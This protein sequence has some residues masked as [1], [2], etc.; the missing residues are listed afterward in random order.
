MKKLLALCTIVGFLAG[1]ETKSTPGGPGVS[2]HDSGSKSPV[3]LSQAEN[4][5]KL[6]VPKTETSI[7][8]G[9][10]K[11]LTIS[12][13]RGK[14][15]AEDVKLSFD[16][17]PKGVKITPADAVL[18]AGDKDITLTIEADKD[19]ALGS[20]TIKVTGTPTKGDATSGDLKIEIKK[21]G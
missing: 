19:A 2:K 3:S 12:I 6:G 8:Q 14:N 15:F 16:S 5:F 18:K 9:E 20:H 17:P 13:D 4:T 1:C 10:T 7:K 11:Q 21:A